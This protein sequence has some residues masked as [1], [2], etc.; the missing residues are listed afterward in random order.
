MYRVRDMLKALTNNNANGRIIVEQIWK[1]DRR[2]VTSSSTSSSSPAAGETRRID[3]NSSIRFLMLNPSV[4]FN[5]IVEKSRSVLLVGGTMQP[6]QHFTNQLFA[7]PVNRPRVNYFSCSHVVP[8]ENIVALSL[9][10]GPTGTKFNFTYQHRNSVEMINELGRVMVNV[11]SIVP[12]GIVCF[13]PSYAYEE[14]VTAAWEASGIAQRIRKKKNM[15]REPRSASEVEAVWNDYLVSV[16]GRQHAASS[17]QGD[18]SSEERRMPQNRSPRRHTGRFEP[19][20]G[21][22]MTCVIGGKMSE[23]INFS[24]DLA[25]C[26]IV[27]GLPYPNARDPVLHEKM[28]YLD[29]SLKHEP[30]SPSPGKVYYENLCMRAVNQSIGR[31]IRHIGDYASIILVDHRYGAP[32]VADQLPG[33][34]RRR[35]FDVTKFTSFFSHLRGFYKH[36]DQK[37]IALAQKANSASMSEQ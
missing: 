35:L 9:H 31:S 20:R 5:E 13:F 6:F 10:N 2:A 18:N 17:S 30:N 8:Q 19:G 24:D 15:L 11:C 36:H 27:V 22:F 37:A 32:R 34:I 26:V 14:K 23:G 21:A 3:Y 33:W 16:R 28:R 12:A 25:R 4:S 1:V 29:S 7:D